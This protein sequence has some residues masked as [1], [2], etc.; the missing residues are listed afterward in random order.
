MEDTGWDETYCYRQCEP[1]QE[2]GCD[3]V[4]YCAPLTSTDSGEWVGAVCVPH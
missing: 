4:H 3:L 2:S 1:A